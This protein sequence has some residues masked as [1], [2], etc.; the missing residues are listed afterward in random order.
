MSNEE[1][2]LTTISGV[3]AYLEP[4]HF[5]AADVHV[6]AGG[7]GNFT[8]RLFL[9]TPLDGRATVVMKHSKS[10]SA[11]NPQFSLDLARQT[12]EARALRQVSAN[13]ASLP[14]RVPAVHL[15]DEDKHVIIMDDA[16]TESTTLKS[17]FLSTN[18]PPAPLARDIGSAIG[19]FLGRLH[20]WGS[21]NDAAMDEFAGNDLGKRITSWIT[22]GMI[23]PTLT[24]TEVPAVALLPEPVSA[25]DLANLRALVE[26]RTDQIHRARETLT[27][28]D[29]WTGNIMVLLADA[30]VDRIT[31]V[32]WE[33]VKPGV[34]ALDVAQFCAEMFAVVLFADEGSVAQDS[35]RV[36]IDAFLT[37]Y[38]GAYTVK[39]GV[40]GENRA[41]VAARHLGAH[42]LTIT[43]RY[44]WGS[45]PEE[46]FRAVK[47]GLEY[48]QHG[49]DEDWVRNKSIFAPLL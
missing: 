6:L 40:D 38:A 21:G 29:F 45:T 33:L 24:T 47:T 17:L 8:Y 15:F 1:H 36:L 30:Q 2:D 11:T 18:P 49:Q 44:G 35:A 4:T 31:V 14:A 13:V 22:Y 5:K 32:D 37:A 20:S 23:L 3:K 26:K 46:T 7:H 25:S 43:T 34:A 12:F 39:H 28:G 19:Q 41:T 10:Y 42:L 27:M 16:G 9:Q 48:L